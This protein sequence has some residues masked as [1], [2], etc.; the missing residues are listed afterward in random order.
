M[1]KVI[2]SVILK[3]EQEDIKNLMLGKYFPWYYLNDVSLKDN[4]DERKPGLAHHFIFNGQPS[5]Y[6][7]HINNLL[8]KTAKK[9]K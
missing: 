9:L 4:P 2:D 8:I 1:I 5:D 7:K 3:K 6:F